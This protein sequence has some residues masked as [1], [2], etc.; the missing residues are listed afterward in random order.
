MATKVEKMELYL[1]ELKKIEKNPDEQLLKKVVDLLW[2]SIFRAD[3]EKVA[4]SD[5]KEM[6]RIWNSTLIAKLWITW[7]IEWACKEICE[8]MWASN[9]NKYRAIFMYFLAKKLW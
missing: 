9:R 4:C 6:E 2:P 5:P 3:A 7:D 8:K 1:E